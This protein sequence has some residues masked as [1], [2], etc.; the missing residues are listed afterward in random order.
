MDYSKVSKYLIRSK[1]GNDSLIISTNL[2]NVS[3]F[4]G[5]NPINLEDKYTY[6]IMR[7]AI[8]LPY[9]KPLSKHEKIITKDNQ[10]YVES[11]FFASY[12]NYTYR[13]TDRNC[14]ESYFDKY[15]LYY[16]IINK[17]H[18]D[19]IN[20]HFYSYDD[21]LQ[22]KLIYLSSSDNINHFYTFFSI[23]SHC[24]EEFK[25][26]WYKR[27]CLDKYLKWL[28]ETDRHPSSPLTEAPNA[29]DYYRSVYMHGDQCDDMIEISKRKL[30]ISRGTDK[31]SIFIG[32]HGK[33]DHYFCVFVHKYLV[34]KIACG[35]EIIKN[36][37]GTDVVVKINYENPY[38]YLDRL[39]GD[40]PKGEEMS[41]EEEEQTIMAY[42]EG[43]YSN[44]IRN[45]KGP[46]NIYLYEYDKDES[47]NNN[48]KNMANI[49][50]EYDRS[51]VDHII[52]E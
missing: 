13:D 8:N 1:V 31:A 12:D 50:D 26:E 35:D 18:K 37:D 17:I 49:K 22:L 38:R 51:L 6:T 28:L 42:I 30:V 23:P 24:Y 5:F 21:N 2:Y 48:Q 19:T 7:E 32:F 46:L 45:G 40:C 25:N 4:I 3:F 15:R 36:I 39:K 34:R 27:E 16:Q 43:M 41:Y 33:G 47:H 10:T 52:V 29:S 44:I 20:M 9:G 11:I 14:A